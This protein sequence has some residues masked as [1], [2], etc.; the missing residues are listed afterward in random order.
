MAVDFA[1]LLG[2]RGLW[3]TLADNDSVC[4]E[5][6]DLAPVAVDLFLNEANLIGGL[7]VRS[8][9]V[10]PFV[11]GHNPVATCVGGWRLQPTKVTASAPMKSIL[12]QSS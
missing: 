5:L 6:A 1:C 10:N 3:R 9:Q 4:R 11:A 2:R 12:K 8:K 7:A